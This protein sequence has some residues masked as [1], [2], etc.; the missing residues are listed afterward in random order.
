MNS[1]FELF[2][3]PDQLL[4][5]VP[6]ELAPVLLKLALPR[7]QGAGFIP[8][9]I[10]EPSVIELHIGKAYPIPKAQMVDK[11]VNSAG[12]WLEREGFAGKAAAESA[13]RRGRRS[14]NAAAAARRIAGR[15]V[16]SLVRLLVQTPVQSRVSPLVGASNCTKHGP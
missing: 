1:L 10:T 6:E 11:F 9:A 14:N 7:Q 3:D 2:P 16:F 8:H 13:S 12:H 4:K 15:G 5:L